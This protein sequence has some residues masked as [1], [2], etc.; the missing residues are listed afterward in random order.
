LGC[1]QTLNAV[2]VCGALGHQALALTRQPTGVL[3]RRSWHPHHSRHLR[4]AALKTQQH[5]QQ[6]ER[7][8]SVCLHSPPTPRRLEARRVQH[9]IFDALVPQPPV[10][11]K[12][13]TS[14]LVAAH[15]AHARM[16]YRLALTLD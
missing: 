3:N 1:Q 9:S 2:A 12:P 11:P 7:V 10:E 13:V 4:L 14:G 16:A 6:P 5:P 15:Y 8:H